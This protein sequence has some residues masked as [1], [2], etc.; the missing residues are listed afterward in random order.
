M[1]AH[2]ISILTLTTPSSSARP[3]TKQLRSPQAITKA[4]AIAAQTF[5]LSANITCAPAKPI[6]GAAV[7]FGVSFGRRDDAQVVGIFGPDSRKDTQAGIRALFLSEKI[8]ISGFAL[9]VT[10]S[11][12]S[13]G[14]NINPYDIR[15]T[16]V[17]LAITSIF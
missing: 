3:N 17:L 6:F 12:S 9:L 11:A 2:A 5:S 16:G 14:S 4:L 1:S 15:Q 8:N 13:T 10:L 7:K